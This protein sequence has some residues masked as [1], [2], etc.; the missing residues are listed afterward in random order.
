MTSIFNKRIK[1]ELNLYQKDN[2][3]F[4]NL[5]LRPN[6]KNLQEWFFIVHDLKDTPFEKGYYFGKILLQNT[7]PLKPA[8][9]IFITPNGRFEENKKICTSF[10]GFHPESYTSTWNILTMMQGIISFMTDKENIKGIGFIDSTDSD[11]II[12]AEKSKEWNKSNDLFNNVFSD[13]NELYLN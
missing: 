9:F 11:K 3:R 2:F 5:Y 8:D 10:S 6:Y 7:Y 12:L 1:N 13:F 4:P